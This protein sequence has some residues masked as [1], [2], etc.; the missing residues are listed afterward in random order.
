LWIKPNRKLA[1]YD[2][3][4]LMRDHLEGTPLD[5]RLDI[6]AGSFGLPYRWRP[7][8]WKVSGDPNLP[9]YCNERATATQQT[10]FV[11]VAE[12]RNRLPDPIGGMLWFYLPQLRALE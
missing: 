2:L 7:L 1:N 6:G 12:C 9:S 5:M 11:F 10:G 3:M 8:T 4:N